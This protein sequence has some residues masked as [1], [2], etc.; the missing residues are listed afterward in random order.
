MLLNPNVQIPATDGAMGAYVA[1]PEGPLRGIVLIKVELWGMTPHMGE[2]AHRLA[3]EGYAAVVCDLF[4]GDTPPVP[5]DPVE[6]WGE[7]FA[8]FDDVRATRDCRHALGWALAG[9]GGRGTAPV[10]AWGFCMGGRFAHNLA[11]FDPRLTG[12]INFYGRLSFPRLMN[13]PF[14]PIEVTRMIAC[15]YLGVFA[16]T[17]GLIPATDVARLDADLAGNPSTA[18]VTYPGTEHAFF[19]DHRESFHAEVAMDAWGRVLAFLDLHR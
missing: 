15:P 11:A 12:A 14:L 18:I 9:C 13:K 2:V 5:T 3:A 7:T 17:D 1:W 10:F 19:N 8:A 16:E 6:T 4:R